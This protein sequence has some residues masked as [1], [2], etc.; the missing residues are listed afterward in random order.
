MLM[1]EIPKKVNHGP[2][3]CVFLNL[4]RFQVKV[5][6]HLDPANAEEPAGALGEE[7]V[8]AHGHQAGGGVHLDKVTPDEERQA[9][10]ASQ[11][12]R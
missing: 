5:L 2:P 4:N 10:G 12:P 3:L 7:S 9:A 8:Q 11:S 1:R 6:G